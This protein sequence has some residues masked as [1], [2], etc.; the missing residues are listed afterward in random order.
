MK[1]LLILCFSTALLF[2]CG[3]DADTSEETSIEMVEPEVEENQNT[4]FAPLAPL[5]SF[6][7]SADPSFAPQNF[8]DFSAAGVMDTLA[9]APIEKK[10]LAPFIPYLIYNNDSSLAIDPYSNNYLL[11][12]SGSATKLVNGSPDTEVALVNF[13]TNRRQRVLYFGPSY[14]LIDAKWKGDSTVLFAFTELIG[15]DKISPEIWEVDVK[16]M[17]KKVS[18][19]P[20]T[21][22]INI[23]AYK[24]ETQTFKRG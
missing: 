6:F 8:P 22:T 12:T 5:F 24:E 10:M 18:R 16:T 2:A 13:K 19:Y 1:R 7:Q 3:N 11:K 20:D 21:L 4:T 17:T 9:A 15:T 23:Q 14:M